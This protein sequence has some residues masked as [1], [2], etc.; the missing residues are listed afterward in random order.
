[1]N[2]I[3]EMVPEHFFSKYGHKLDADHRKNFFIVRLQ[4]QGN[5]DTWWLM[6]KKR[7]GFLF[8]SPTF[9]S[10]GGFIWL[11]PRNQTLEPRT[12]SYKYIVDTYH[13]HVIQPQYAQTD[14]SAAFTDIG[15]CYR[16]P[17]KPFNSRTVGFTVQWKASDSLII[18]EVKQG[19]GGNE[20]ILNI[21]DMEQAKFF[22]KKPE[23]QYKSKNAKD[24]K[25]S[26]VR[27]EFT[28]W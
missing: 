9:P 20:Y 28:E 10:T 21:K 13:D 27:M 24:L 3:A 7:H 26:R 4:G 25:P 12:P 16:V 19:G 1:M 11:D 8:F 15:K 14:N 23:F 17:K 22:R 2:R 18:Q 6:W 5:D